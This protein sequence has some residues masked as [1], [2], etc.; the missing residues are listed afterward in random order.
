MTMAKPV[1]VDVPPALYAWAIERSRIERDD[2]LRR[3][4][5]LTDWEAGDTAP[6]LKQLEQFAKA[7]HT[8]VG[9]FFL[10]EPPAENVPIPDFRTMSDL[11]IA[12]PSA[13]LLDTVYQCEQRQEWFRDY[14]QAE[15]L[16]RV[17][18]VGSCTVDTDVIDAAA[19]MRDVLA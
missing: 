2:L 13:D 8:P 12:R 1:R 7:T 6:T 3:F 17:P 4:P 11:V 15:R 10:L 19:R 18:F 5:K 9:F 14:A 16:D